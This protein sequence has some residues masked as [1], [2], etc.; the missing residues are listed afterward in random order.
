[1]WF[2]NLTLFRFDDALPT[3]AQQFAEA[4]ARKPFK[5][6][7]SHEMETRGWVPPLGRRA[8]DL[9]HVAGGFWLFCLQTEQKVLPAAVVREMLDDQV[10]QIEE[11]EMRR[12]FR[13]EKE[14][15]KDEIM[16][17]LLPRALT[18]SR[19]CYAC[20]DTRTERLLVDAAGR[21]AVE[22]LTTTLRDT[23]GRLPIRPLQS[24]NAPTAA[25]TDW[26]LND[27]VPKELA[28]EDE[29]ELRDV[30]DEGGVVRCRGQDLSGD[31]MLTLLQAGK[32]VTRLALCWDERISFLLQDDLT[33]RRLRFHERVQEQVGDV[34]DDNDA[35][36]HDAEI[37][38]M[39]AE[40][41]LLLDRLLA[42]FGGEAES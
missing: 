30:G 36:R 28:L 20:V 17:T 37:V 14:R 26:M 16:H 27:A 23:L 38:V 10:A 32:V 1:M 9:V 3:D 40:L 33:L 41:S 42:G 7:A 8:S 21:K 15:L 6:C 31:E 39:T 5:P 25:M 24:A 13:K 18:R 12:V 2:K 22:E 11:R 4:L 29:C 34:D 19:R 35:L